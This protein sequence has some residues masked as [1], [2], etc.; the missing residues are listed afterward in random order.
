ARVLLVE[1][2]LLQ[3]RGA[4]TAVLGRPPEADPAVA[5]EFLFPCQSFFEQFVLVAGSAAPAYDREPVAETI[6][7]P[8]SRV[9]AEAFLVGGEAQVHRE[10][11]HAIA[12]ATRWS[13]CGDGRE[14]RNRPRRRNR[15]GGARLRHD[16]DDERSG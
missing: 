5:A 2:D 1:D 11:W 9:G 7:E 3:Q 14:P 15:N 10:T 4:A 16:R 12:Q 13:C 6:G 8:R